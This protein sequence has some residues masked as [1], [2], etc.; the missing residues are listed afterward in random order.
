[1]VENCFICLKKETLSDFAEGT[2]FTEVDDKLYRPNDI[3][4][5][6]G[7]SSKAKRELGWFYDM[8]PCQLL[9][10]LLAD[11]ETLDNVS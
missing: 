3:P 9:D 7:D 8:T 4:E 6:F 10:H 1:M 2:T 5:I 11:S